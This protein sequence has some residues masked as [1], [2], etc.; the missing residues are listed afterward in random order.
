[1]QA[2]QQVIYSTDCSVA[3]VIELAT[4]NVDPQTTFEG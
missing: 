4:A 1:M 2:L 3:V